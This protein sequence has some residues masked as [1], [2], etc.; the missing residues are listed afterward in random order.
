MVLGDE[1]IF[2]CVIDVWDKAQNLQKISFLALQTV[3]IIVESST[4]WSVLCSLLVKY[5]RQCV[6]SVIKEDA[7][8]FSVSVYKVS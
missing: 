5:G 6:L 2:A 4:V 8:V 1:S 7:C 3:L